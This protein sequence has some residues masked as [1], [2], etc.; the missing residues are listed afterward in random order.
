MEMIR[1][2]NKRSQQ[3]LQKM[4]NPAQGPACPRKIW[5]I[6]IQGQA[7]GTTRNSGHFGR[8]GMGSARSK[9]GRYSNPGCKSRGP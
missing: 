5:F 8:H 7:L 4:G 6:I 2:A 9:L 3:G 1:N